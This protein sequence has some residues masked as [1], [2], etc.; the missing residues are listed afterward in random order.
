MIIRIFVSR[1]WKGSISGLDSN[2][3]ATV[4]FQ[5]AY[6]KKCRLSGSMSISAEFREMLETLQPETVSPLHQ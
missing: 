5:G 6:L 4:S 3:K 2:Y 1:S